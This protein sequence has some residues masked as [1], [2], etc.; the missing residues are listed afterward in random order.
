[1]NKKKII[2]QFIIFSLVYSVISLQLFQSNSNEFYNNL[3]SNY[4][5]KSSA[6]SSFMD[7]DKDNYSIFDDVTV[8]VSFEY[9]INLDTGTYFTF[10]FSS[11]EDNFTGII[12]ESE[13]LIELHEYNEFT[14]YVKDYGLNISDEGEF[15]YILFLFYGGTVLESFVYNSTKIFI[16]KESLDYLFNINGTQINYYESINIEINLFAEDNFSLF[17]S[18]IIINY[19]VFNRKENL[20]WYYLTSTDNYGLVNITF[21]PKDYGEVGDYEILIIYNGSQLFKYLLLRLDFEVIR[22]GVSIHL[23][24][25]T[26][27]S[28]VLKKGEQPYLSYPVWINIMIDDQIKFDPLIQPILGYNHYNYSF[29]NYGNGTY[30]YLIELENHEQSFPLRIS[31]NSTCFFSEENE[32]ILN[33]TKREAFLDFNISEILN[34]SDGKNIY[35]FF[36][37]IDA[38]DYSNLTNF[39]QNFSILYYHSNEWKILDDESKIENNKYFFNL[40]SKSLDILY[41]IIMGDLVLKI[42]FTGNNIFFSENSSEFII[43]KN[44]PNVEEQILDSNSAPSS[45]VNLFNVSIIVLT[46]SSLIGVCYYG[47]IVYNT[48]FKKEFHLKRLKI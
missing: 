12:F 1:M 48:K 38:Q 25:N 11:I 40:T 32:I 39:S 8:F 45:P 43:V 28:V 6:I 36:E 27:N 17:P 19:E 16:E 9:G 20:I 33:L 10:A 34:Y 5:P 47:I 7:T 3:K 21:F 13:H 4:Q 23:N 24:K 41:E 2:F 46:A 31:V 26:P 42:S 22:K 29:R 14:F 15:Y 37:L 18:N 30:R 35:I 44:P